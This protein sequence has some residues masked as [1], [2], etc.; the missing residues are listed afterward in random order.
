MDGTRFDNMNLLIT[1]ADTTQV[2]KKQ[3][4]AD[5]P[6]INSFA[7]YLDDNLVDSEKNQVEEHM[8]QCSSCRTNF[9]EL[10]MLLDK[11]Q[12][13]AP[14]ELADNVKKN[15]QSTIS[16]PTEGRKIKI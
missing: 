7:G 5:C 2:E 16:A 1:P 11:E 9:Y 8:A 14:E 10:R 6:D 3:K 13:V 4:N 15:I 12:Q